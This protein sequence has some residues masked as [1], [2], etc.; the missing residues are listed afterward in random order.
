M[1]LRFKMTF[2]PWHQDTW[3]KKAGSLPALRLHIGCGDIQFP[4]WINIDAQKVRGVDLQWDVR[5]PLP[6]PDGGVDA[7]YSHHMFEYLEF[8]DESSALIKEFYRVLKPGGVLRLVI[9]DME[10][11]VRSYANGDATFFKQLYRL[12]G[13]PPMRT[14]CEI[15]NMMFRM[16]T[17]HLFAYDYETLNLIFSESGFDNIQKQT[18]DKC[19]NPVFHGLDRKEPWFQLESLYIEAEK[20]RSN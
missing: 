3:K 2:S 11:Y 12:G 16:G 14:P 19:T 7:I 20:T 18:C 1:M 10:K 5:V 13:G 6:F 4:D 15:I 9:P 8:P 17:S